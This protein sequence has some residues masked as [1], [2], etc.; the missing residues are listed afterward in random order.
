MIRA[1]NCG[2]RCEEWLMSK[3]G[4]EEWWSC[5]RLAWRVADVRDGWERWDGMWHGKHAGVYT[6]DQ[7]EAFLVDPHGFLRWHNWPGTHSAKA[8]K[9]ATAQHHVLMK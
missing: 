9:P 8:Q 4:T 6:S 2:G 7:L 3:I 5:L 1:G